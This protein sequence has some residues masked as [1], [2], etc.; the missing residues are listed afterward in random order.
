MKFAFY[1]GCV[2]RGGCPELYP[3][4]LMV[5]D[6]LGIEL[7]ELTGAACTGSGV[8][9]EKDEFLGDTLNARTFAM[10]ENLGLPVMTICSTCQGVMS[11]ANKRLIGDPDYLARVNEILSEEGLEYKGGTTV[12]H[13]LWILVEDIGVDALKAQFTRS[14]DDLRVA[15]FYGCYIIRPSWA[16]EFD[17][18]PGRANSLE[19]LIEAVGAT[20]VDTEGKT[21]CC[22][23]PILTINE[24]NSMAMVGKHTTEAQDLGA[25][26]MVTPCPLCH[27]NLDGFQPTAASQLGVSIHMPIL[28]LPQLIGLALGFS[29]KEMGMD[30]HI[31]ST[32]QVQDAIAEAQPATA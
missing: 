7:E 23:F 15:P 28:H 20:L 21:R 30:R 24:K 26:A 2:S 11:Q 3:A 17:E 5:C 4:T 13:L 16:L 22:G 19:S 14:L 6:R 1:P 10:A 31:V 8:L 18:N 25:N 29:P 27:L 32:S 9:Q 12:K